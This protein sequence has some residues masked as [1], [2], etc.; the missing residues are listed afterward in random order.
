VAGMAWQRVAGEEVVSLL[1]SIAH[2]DAHSRE[3]VRDKAVRILGRGVGQGIIPESATGLVNGY[4]HSGKTLSFMTLSVL[5]KNNG[6]DCIIVITGISVPLFEQS[7]SRLDRDLRL[8]RRAD[9]QW[10]SLKNPR[11]DGD[12]QRIV[13]AV[14]A[15]WAD[16]NV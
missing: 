4:E 3:Y 16:G 14:L 1:D 12:T 2:L 10:L 15:D 8:A 11:A 9:R 5:V 13:N 6:F 7:S